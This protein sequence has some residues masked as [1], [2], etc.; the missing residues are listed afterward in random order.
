MCYSSNHA[1]GIHE[2]GVWTVEKHHWHRMELGW[3]RH[4]SQNSHT[5]KALSVCCIGRKGGTT[6]DDS[7]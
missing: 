6:W 3:D 2:G 4:G 7:C 5:V 1:S